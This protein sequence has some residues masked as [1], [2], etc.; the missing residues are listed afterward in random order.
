MDE[1]AAFEDSNW[2]VLNDLSNSGK[3]ND[4]LI[5]ATMTCNL[6]GVLTSLKHGA[7]PNA[8]RDMY[9][10]TAL[11]YA[12]HHGQAEMVDALICH[13]ADVFVQD[14]DGLLPIHRAVLLG[15]G[16]IVDHLKVVDDLLTAMESTSQ[17]MLRPEPAG[18]LAAAAL[19]KYQQHIFQAYLH[20]KMHQR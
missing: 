4:D 1:F 7:D 14:N 2:N 17:S 18:E 10:L 13:E 15:P 19:E 11:H 5:N 20:Y 6:D 16:T 9:G 8:S 3:L 12:A